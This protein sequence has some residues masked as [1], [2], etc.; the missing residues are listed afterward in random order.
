MS[1]TE[2]I[3]A[4][5]EPEVA[6]AWAMA[7]IAIEQAYAPLLASDPLPI[8]AITAACGAWHFMLNNSDGISGGLLPYAIRGRNDAAGARCLL[9]MTGGVLTNYSEDR[10]LTDLAL[11]MA[12]RPLL[13]QPPS[14]ADPEAAPP[15][16]P[17]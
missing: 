15:G 3:A 7:L 17:S 14:A 12:V 8:G 4:W 11:L 9:H 6:E 16:D 13:G 10:F 2:A 1:V 5:R